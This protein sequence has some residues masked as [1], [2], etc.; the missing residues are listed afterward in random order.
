MNR[1]SNPSSPLRRT[2]LIG[3]LAGAA[4]LALGSF[5]G[6]R[7]ASGRGAWIADVVRRNLPGFVIDEASI[8][9][10]V[11]DVLASGLLDARE[12]R[13]KVLAD[14]TIPALRRIAP[15]RERMERLERLVLTEFLMG[16]NFFAGVETQPI[17]YSG[18]NAA[19]GNPFAN[20]APGSAVRGRRLAAWSKGFIPAA[21]AAKAGR[22]RRAGRSSRRAPR[23]G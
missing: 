8:A 18:R 2:L 4:A 7:L 15:A 5:A 12:A 20:L 11:R 22:K 13:L 23:R 21:A 17:V 19:C 6:L 14:T 3:G 1:S 10:F 9:I 16:S